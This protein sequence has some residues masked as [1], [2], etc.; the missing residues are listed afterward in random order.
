MR[1]QLRPRLAAETNTTASRTFQPHLEEIETR[2]LPGEAVGLGLLASFGV[3]G[4]FLSSPLRSTEP[5]SIP[6][7]SFRWTEKSDGTEPGWLASVRVSDQAVPVVS[8]NIQIETPSRGTSDMIFS[9]SVPT[10]DLGNDLLDPANWFGPARRRALHVGV[11]PDHGGITADFAVVPVAG[12]S[13]SSSSAAAPAASSSNHAGLGTGTNPGAPAVG[14]VGPV[15]SGGFVA[16]VQG[17]SWSSYAHDAQHTAISEV[18]SQPLAGVRWQTPVDLNPQ[19][20]GDELLIHYGSP[21]VTQ[22]NT[23]IVPVKTGSNDGFEVDGIDG[24]TGALKW[25]V[26]TDY[27]VPDSRWTPP[28]SPVLAPGNRLY[29]PGAGG[30]IYYM[31]NPDGNGATI[32]GHFAFYGISNY[33]HS[34]DSNVKI[35]TPLTSDSLGDIY[36][37]FIVYGPTPLNLES[38]V[39]RMAPN[40]HGSWV[41]A[42]AAAADPAITQVL[43][44]CAPALSNDENSLYVAVSTGSAFGT[45]YLLRLDSA[46]LATTGEVFLLDPASGQAALLAD[47]GTASPTVGPDGDVYF[48]VLENPFLSNHARGWLLHFSGDLT[49]NRI[50]GAFGWDDTAAVVPAAMVPSY[51]G[52]SSYLL[53]TKY[54]DYK[55]TGGDGVNK[56]AVLDPNAMRDDPITG[57]CV[58]QEVLTIAGVTPDPVLPMVREWCINTAAV[59]PF[60]KSILVNSEDGF[61][62]RWDTVHNS[63]TQTVS[64]AGPLG[65]AY[66]PTVIGV[67]GTVYAINNAIL[68]AVGSP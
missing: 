1:H 38:G 47:S 44:N 37:G 42:S 68:F 21:L 13:F 3:F 9:G 61:L 40:G 41:A 36:F 39:A 48:G 62:Y 10:E 45:G 20:S 7:S 54:N 52:S 8:H 4:S 34:Y 26:S 16:Q 49:Q 66:T 29:I 23:V 65:E 46:T 35:S 22:A 53:M 56:L 2:L 27:S 59:D 33:D 24:R 6:A 50:P 12:S 18:P 30:T 51:T 67:D 64:L 25:T 43:L 58:M 14:R 17:P 19:Y 57:A 5:W 55:E 15:P 28:M 31:D 63:F 32:S 11:D 60:T